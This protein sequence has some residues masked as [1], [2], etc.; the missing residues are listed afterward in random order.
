MSSKLYAEL[1]IEYKVKSNF[2]NF[3]KIKFLNDIIFYQTIIF[4]VSLL[5]LGIF[6]IF[7]FKDNFIKSIVD[8]EILTLRQEGVA[9]MCKNR[10]K[11]SQFIILSNNSTTRCADD[12]FS[13]EEFKNIGINEYKSDEHYIYNHRVIH[14]KG[15][16]YT[17]FL[18]VE[19]DALKLV[20]S[21]VFSKLFI[22][23]G[24]LGL[25]FLTGQF[26]LFKHYFTPLYNLFN[27]FKMDGVINTED[28]RDYWDYIESKSLKSFSKRRKLHRELFNTRQYYSVIINSIDDPLAVTDA[29]GNIIFCNNSFKDSFASFNGHYNKINLIN[30]IRDYDFI[31]LIK[32]NGYTPTRIHNSQI[33]LTKTNGKAHSFQL[34]TS[35]IDSKKKEKEILFFFSDITK[36]QDMNN[37][38]RDFFENVSHEIKTPLTSIK[39]YS[40]TLSAINTDVDQK[41]ILDIITQNVDRLDELINGIL[42][43]SKIENEGRITIEDIDFSAFINGLI[44]DQQIKLDAKNMSIDTSAIKVDTVMANE[45]LLYHCL[46]NLLSNAIKYSQ[47]RTKITISGGI[48]NNDEVYISITDEGV[49]IPND[50]IARIFERFY[51]VDQSRSINTGGTGLGLAIAKHSA[52]KM[53]ARIEVDSEVNKGTTFIVIFPNKKS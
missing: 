53:G 19:S 21:K 50:K 24:I 6:F 22:S 38:R 39:G 3:L 18:K 17:L 2:F 45:R 37:M 43:L 32:T 27:I 34:K 49:G 30:I 35:S 5:T 8:Q 40:Q 16:N 4:C 41:E 1:V 29:K 33:K 12:S 9:K 31:N 47:E 42:S 23:M 7:N 48:Y 15:K 26:F 10:T 25:L 11:R 20:S 36:L 46:S 44:N 14:S 52:Q 28:S 51:R 13:I